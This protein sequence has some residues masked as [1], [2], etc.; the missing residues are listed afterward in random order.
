VTLVDPN[1]LAKHALAGLDVEF[2]KKAQ[3]RVI[4]GGGKNLNCGSSREQAPQD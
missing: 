1:E 3:K 4:L 2:P